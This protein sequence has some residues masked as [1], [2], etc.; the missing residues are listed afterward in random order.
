MVMVHR[1]I[2]DTILG[3]QIAY[4]NDDIIGWGLTEFDTYVRHGLPVIAV[5]GNDA[6]WS[7]MYRD[8]IRLLKDPVATELSFTHYETVAEGFGAKGIL[9]RKE[10]QVII[11]SCC[12]VTSPYLPYHHWM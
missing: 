6:C 11:I 9:V 2:H 7:Q 3:E 4:R 1:V 12:W 8:Q 5:I 10:S